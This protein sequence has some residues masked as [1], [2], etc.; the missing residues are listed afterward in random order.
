GAQGV[1]RIGHGCVA[2]SGSTLSAGSGGWSATCTGNCATVVVGSNTVYTVT[3]SPAFATS[4][5]VVVTPGIPLPFV[6]D[7]VRYPAVPTLTARAPGSFE[8]RFGTPNAT[9]T[10]SFPNEFCFT[11][12]Q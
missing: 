6:G 7:G 8:V 3:F 9:Y 11:A 2:A 1:A 4:P 10:D 5:S 12:M